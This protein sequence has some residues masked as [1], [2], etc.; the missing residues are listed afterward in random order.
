MSLKIAYKDAFKKFNKFTIDSRG[1]KYDYASVMHYGMNAFSVNGKPTIQAKQPEI[2]RGWTSWSSWTSCSKSCGSGEQ[3]KTRVCTSL[4]D[5]VPQC[6]GANVQERVCN[7][8]TCPDWPVFPHNFSFR[9]DGSPNLKCALIYERADYQDWTNYL[10]CSEG[11]R[12]SE[13]KWSDMGA[14]V[15]MKCTNIFEPEEPASRSWLDNYLCVPEYA[16]YNFTWSYNGPIPGL[17]C[18][19]WYA[20]EGRDGWDNN[21]L[22]AAGQKTNDNPPTPVDGNWGSWGQ[23]ALC[24]K[25]CD[26]GK[27]RR[28]RQ[29][30]NPSPAYG[31]KM[32]AGKY[33]VDADCNLNRC[34][35]QKCGGVLDGSKGEFT[36]PNYPRDYPNEQNCTWIIKGDAKKRI[37]LYLRSFSFEAAFGDPP[38][39][40][41]DFLT[42]RQDGPH[43]KLLGTFCGTQ[44]PKPIASDSNILWVNMITDKTDQ[45]AGFRATWATIGSKPEDCG[46]DFR[47]SFGLIKSPGFPDKYPHK[48]TCIWNIEAPEGK[49]VTFNFSWFDIEQHGFCKYDYVEIRDGWKDNS[50]QLGRYCTKKPPSGLVST[51]NQVRIKFVTD[52][53]TAKTGFKLRWKAVPK[54]KIIS[55]ARCPVSWKLFENTPDGPA[56]YVVK[57]N[58]FS[59]YGARDDC[60][61][62]SADLLSITS[63]DEQEFVTTE[64]LNGKFMWLGYTDKDY[65]GHWAWS[66]NS[67]RPSFTNW[68]GG[69]PNDGGWL[70]NE[71]CALMK[72][73]GKWNDYPCNDRFKYICKRKPYR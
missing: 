11:E 18:L 41:F 65:E 29:C 55:A 32:C 17:E 23:W 46:G 52:E 63:Q 48:R 31:G 15:G 25:E 53:T 39:C 62:N 56:C 13:M 16:P 34:E 8:H 9:V 37:I 70:R 2:N 19:Q 60:L 69:D 51:Q 72:P 64:L 24:S 67:T 66:D 49:V 59:W 5:G 22:C 14:T 61:A 42:I 38:R 57:N 6:P 58:Y 44:K 68:D 36:S 35:V 43:G 50:P 10:F 3:K 20:K 12:D 45:R 26:G 28:L 21:Y 4:K 40:Q 47:N 54:E 73:D 27:K 1:V 71:D 30:N 33:F 7:P